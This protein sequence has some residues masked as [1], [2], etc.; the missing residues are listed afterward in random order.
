ML[1]GQDLKKLRK[2]QIIIQNMMYVLII[3]LVASSFIFVQSLKAFSFLAGAICLSSFIIGM[4]TRKR[5]ELIEIIVPSMKPLFD[6]ERD[7][8]GVEYWILKKRQ[9]VIQA[10]LTVMM[11]LQ[12][13]MIPDTNSTVNGRPDLY[14]LLPMA[15]IMFA[16]F[17]ISS[18]LHIKKVDKSN[19]IEMKGYAN[20][21][22][23]YGI[24]GGIFLGGLIT[25][26]I[27]ASFSM[28]LY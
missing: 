7:K 23:L 5:G 20:K 24:I 16:V 27:I 22:L 9:L 11:V 13:I 15:L 19:T 17:N 4:I 21:T 3:L 6:Y 18:Y 8:L 12:G 1:T 26:A 28:E 2:Q 25:F 10:L 14:V